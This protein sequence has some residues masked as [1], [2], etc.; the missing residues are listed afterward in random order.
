[1]DDTIL[2]SSCGVE[3]SWGLVC[4]EFAGRLSCEPEPLRLAIRKSAQEFWRDESLAG[5][6]RVKLE[7]SRVLYIEAALRDEGLDV[8]HAR[9]LAYRYDSEVTARY[10]LFDDAVETLEWLRT[11]GFAMCLL[12]NGPQAMQRAKI[13]R[14]G[15]EPYFDR[16]VIEG[17]F[18]HGKPDRQVFEHALSTS[19]VAAADAWHVGDNLY[20]DIGGA[21]AVGIHAVWIHRERLEMKDDAPAV[22][23]RVIG[24]LTELREALEA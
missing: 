14:F 7:E 12:T 13:S 1:M 18:G 22:P 16:I 21:Q 4:R 24:H 6:W 17:E 20:A 3:E 2:D 9:D 23:D 11:Q 15:L 10:R 5:H 8:S 19:N